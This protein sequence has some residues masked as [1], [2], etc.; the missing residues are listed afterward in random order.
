VAR[1][2]AI[3]GGLRRAMIRHIEGR[4]FGQEFAIAQSSCGGLECVSVSAI[5]YGGRADLCESLG[6]SQTQPTRGARNK[7]NA[8]LK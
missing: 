6:H 4:D 8:A 5:Q 1:N 3:Y 2:N 7:G